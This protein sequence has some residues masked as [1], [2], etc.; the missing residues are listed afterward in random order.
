[1]WNLVYETS[2]ALGEDPAR[3]ASTLIPPRDWSLDRTNALV[4]RFANTDNLS[5]R[6]H[7]TH[8]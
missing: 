6:T 3:F 7:V 2:L 1:L 5:K 8:R 4:N